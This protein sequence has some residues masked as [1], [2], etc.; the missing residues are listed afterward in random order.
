MIRPAIEGWLIVD[1]SRYVDRYGMLT[2]DGA[3]A[4]WKGIAP[5]PAGTQVRLR[6]G[7][8]KSLAGSDLAYQLG[9][10]GISDASFI[11]VEGSEPDGIA[12]ILGALRTIR[13]TGRA[14]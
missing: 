6:I 5:A 1:I 8:M 9:D 12:A 3:F 14:A 4:A 2:K 13:D 11:E 7:A 10:A